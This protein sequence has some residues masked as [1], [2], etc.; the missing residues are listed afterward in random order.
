MTFGFTATYRDWQKTRQLDT[1]ANSIKP[2]GR[3]V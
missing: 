1:D 2:P 3:Y